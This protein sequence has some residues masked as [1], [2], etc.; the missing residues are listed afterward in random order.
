MHWCIAL[1]KKIHFCFTVLWSLWT[2]VL[3]TY[4][5]KLCRDMCWWRHAHLLWKV[6]QQF[7]GNVSN[8][9]QI[10]SSFTC[11]FF[12]CLEQT[13]QEIFVWIYRVTSYGSVFSIYI[14]QKTHDNATAFPLRGLHKHSHTNTYMRDWVRAA[15]WII[16]VPCNKVSN[17]KWPTIWAR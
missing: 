14:I 4:L 15:W 5:C 13:Y 3:Y 17:R 6:K 16:E 1:L 7:L 9:A 12:M 8:L 10:S 11:K 2:T